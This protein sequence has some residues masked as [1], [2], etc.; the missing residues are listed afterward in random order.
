[1]SSDR[2][3]RMALCLYHGDRSAG[4]AAAPSDAAPALRTFSTPPA[5]VWRA[6]HDGRRSW[7][8]ARSRRERWR[9]VADPGLRD[10]TVTR[11]SLSRRMPFVAALSL[12]MPLRFLS[13]HFGHLALAILAPALGVALVCAIDVCSR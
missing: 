3:A 5:M 13:G 2:R 9:V 8:R 4:R 11:T 1:L 12:R 10:L 6:G 7:R